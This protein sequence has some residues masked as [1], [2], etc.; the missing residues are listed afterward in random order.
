MSAKKGWRGGKK[1]CARCQVFKEPAKFGPNRALADGLSAYCRDCKRAAD[2]GEDPAP[3]AP[4]APVSPPSKVDAPKKAAAKKRTGRPSKLVPELVE[5]IVELL[6]KGHT[7]RAAAAKV[8]IDET[9]FQRWYAQGREEPSGPHHDFMIAVH[10]AEG[11]GEAELESKMLSAA[12]I[13]P[14]HARWVLE[15][16]YHLDWARKDVPPPTD[17]AKPMEAALVRELLLKRIAGLTQPFTE[18]TA[19]PPAPP[20]ES[21]DTAAAGGAA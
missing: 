4:P 12:D 18:P 19:A 17:G 20:P 7:R 5:Q 8:G 9:T 21:A 6:E 3:P 2:R 13:D 14:L 10:T 11:V 15:R 1:R 16:R